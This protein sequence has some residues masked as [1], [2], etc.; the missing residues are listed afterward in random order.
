LA[1][2]APLLVVLEDLHWGDLASLDLVSALAR[3]RG[4]ARL[5]LLA[6]YRPTEV[7][8]REHPLASV[9]QELLLRRQCQALALDLLSESAVAKYLTL[10]F[11]KSAA[12]LARR[13]HGHTEGNPLFLVNVVDYLVVQGTIAARG[14]GWELPDRLAAVELGV[15]DSIRQMLE[16]QADRL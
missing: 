7:A 9:T 16:R 15:P 11:G 3:R 5:L 8:V 12:A 2:E 14:G 4:P 1:G 10:R 13:L 6:T